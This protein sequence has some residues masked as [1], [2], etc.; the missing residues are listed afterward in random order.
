MGSG[1]SKTKGSGTSCTA[2]R[3]SLILQVARASRT[4]S[5]YAPMFLGGPTWHRYGQAPDQYGFPYIELWPF[6]IRKS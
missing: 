3:S 4:G 6:C 2:G 5:E 1:T